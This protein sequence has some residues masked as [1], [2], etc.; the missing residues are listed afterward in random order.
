LVWC[1]S[2][3]QGI[4]GQEDETYAP[5]S[6]HFS[7]INLSLNGLNFNQSIVDSSGHV[8]NS[9]ADILTRASESYA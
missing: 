8:L 3:G 2:I 7:T 5:W 4:F 1:C 6:G 9:W